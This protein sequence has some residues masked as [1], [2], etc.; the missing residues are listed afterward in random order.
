MKRC[1]FLLPLIGLA[2]QL[3]AQAPIYDFGFVRNSEI[4]VKDMHNRPLQNAWAGGLTGIAAVAIHLNSDDTLDLVLFEKLGNRIVPFL[5]QNGKYHYAPQY[6]GYFP[7]LHDW[8]RFADYDHDGKPDI[9]TYGLG[10]ITVYRNIS[11]NVP[12]FE[13]VCEQLQSYY[14]NGYTNLYAASDDYLAIADLDNDGD[15]DILNFGVLGRYVHFHRNYAVENHYANGALDFRLA[16]D[17]WGRFEEGS[18]NNV[19]TLF[20]NCGNKAETE[21]TRHTGSSLSLIKFFGDSLFDLVVGDMDF[22]DLILLTNGGT[23]KDALMTA[24]TTDFPNALM[25]VQLYSMPVCSF[26]TLPPGNTPTL[27]ISPSDPRMGKSQD[28]NSVWCYQKTAATQQY[29]L[30]ST[31]FL[32]EDMID[33]GSGAYPVFFDWNGDGLQDLF[34]ANWGSFD[35]ASYRDGILQSYFASSISYYQNTG[36]AQQ[37]EFQQITDDFGNL[38]SL[39]IKGLYPA[40]GDFNSDGI[41]DMLC[42]REEGSLTLFENSAPNGLL[43]VFNSHAENYKNINVA[44]YSAP[45]YFDLDGDGKND[46]LIGNRRG[47]IA[48][49]KNISA[50]NIPDFQLITSNLGN[51]DVRDYNYSYFGN[52]TPCFFRTDAGETKLFCGTNQG[53]LYYYTD[54]DHNLDGGFTLAELPLF[55]IYNQRRIAIREGIRT[56]IAVANLNNDN[57][58]DIIAGNWAGGLS[59][60]EGTTPPDSTITAVPS[61]AAPLCDI[62]QLYPNPA[63]DFSILKGSNLTSPLI[64]RDITGRTVREIPFS[65]PLHEIKIDAAGLKSGIY[66]VHAGKSVLKLIKR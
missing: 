13:M 25:P 19:L 61:P 50:S 39:N 35:S 4:T 28:L 42:G 26:I 6:A 65:S 44:G 56:G 12:A 49:Y 18:D 59:Y 21:Q 32:Q 55:E 57:Y 16:D 5:W 7:R 10:G 20:S 54:I 33:V 47:F 9:F 34:I 64:I 27:I 23:K 15:L 14:Y 45:Q 52:S 60:F 1:F 51:V 62:P 48:Y 30:V 53:Y 40:F 41:P 24:Q 3:A 29:E 36:T 38:K 8:V 63:T 2:I 11:Q 31:A 22:P 43:P 66:F 46:L 58:I 17:C 37:P